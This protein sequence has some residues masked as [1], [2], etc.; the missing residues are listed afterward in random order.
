[1][2]QVN[3]FQAKTDLSKLIC[4]LEEGIDDEIVIARNG[5]PVARLLKWEEKPSDRRIGV[6]KG[7]FRAPEDFDADDGLIEGMFAAEKP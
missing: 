4:A 1:M 7:L 6:A 2:R 3:V 5:K